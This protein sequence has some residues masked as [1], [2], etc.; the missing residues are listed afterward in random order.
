MSCQALAVMII[1]M[2]RH[3]VLVGSGESCPWRSEFIFVSNIKCDTSIERAR[4]AL[5][6]GDTGSDPKLTYPDITGFEDTRNRDFCGCPV[7]VGSSRVSEDADGLGRHFD[8]RFGRVASPVRELFTKNDQNWPKV[9]RN[10]FFVLGTKD[11]HSNE[12]FLRENTDAD[13][14]T[15]LRRFSRELSASKVTQKRF[16]GCSS[17]ICDAFWS[18]SV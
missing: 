8:V 2:Q 18:P 17:R 9:G 1:L 13:R 15:D 11:D 7:A 5:F 6:S 10:S 4:R 3:Q 16:F 14:E 12:R